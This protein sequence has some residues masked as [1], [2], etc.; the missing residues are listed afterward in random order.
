MKTKPGASLFNQMYSLHV[1]YLFV[2][3]MKR[4]PLKEYQLYNKCSI[5][6]RGHEK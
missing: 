4:Y 6:Q 5:I 1:K 2:S 3:Y